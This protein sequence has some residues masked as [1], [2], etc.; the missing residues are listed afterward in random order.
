MQQLAQAAGAAWRRWRRTGAGWGRK[1]S[2]PGSTRAERPNGNRWTG[3]GSTAE[4]KL[5][6]I[7]DQAGLHLRHPARA[8]KHQRSTAI[9]A[10]GADHRMH[11][12]QLPRH[13]AERDSPRP[14]PLERS[15][16]TGSYRGPCLR[17]EARTRVNKRSEPG[18]A[19]KTRC[20]TICLGSLAER[21]SGKCLCDTRDVCD[22]SVLRGLRMIIGPCDSRDICD[23]S[24][25]LGGKC[26]SCRKCRKPIPEK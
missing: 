17:P 21:C 2:A 25:L 1:V 12:Q 8:R 9:D 11:P 4:G 3:F 14:V 22:T 18:K 20:G 15:G 16:R 5:V 24:G 19:G 7:A 6:G 13:P 23:S 10:D 26:R